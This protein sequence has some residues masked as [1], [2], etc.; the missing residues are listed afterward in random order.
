MAETLELFGFTLNQT[1]IL[2]SIDQYLVETDIE[3]S[4]ADKLT[5]KTARLH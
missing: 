3:G 2:F 5:L 4:K 1:R